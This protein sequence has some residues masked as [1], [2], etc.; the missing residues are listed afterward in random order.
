MITKAPKL[1]D[2]GER[3]LIRAIGGEEITFTKFKIGNGE[4]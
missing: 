2:A 1:T 3:L 4:T